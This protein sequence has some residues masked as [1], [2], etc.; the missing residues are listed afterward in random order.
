[1]SK[2][3]SPIKLL[4]TLDI[5][6]F[7]ESEESIQLQKTVTPEQS[8]ILPYPPGS[9]SV[10]PF[11]QS[12][13]Y[14]FK[15]GNIYKNIPVREIPYFF[16]NDKVTYARYEDRN[17]PTNLSIK[18]LEQELVPLF[19]RIHKSYL[20]NI[21]AI[22]TLHINNKQVQIKGENLPIGNYYYKEFIEQLDIIK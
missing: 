7:Y 20:V 13:H 22:E 5:A 4:N 6:F 19:Q 3:L 10:I 21:H 14:F 18:T 8:Q 2:E 11:Q 1:M 16:S 15:I 12:K 17:F 9:N